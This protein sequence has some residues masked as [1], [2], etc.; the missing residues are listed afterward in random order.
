MTE[1][2]LE[3]AIATLPD[4]LAQVATT[5]AGLAS[6]SIGYFPQSVADTAVHILVEP[7]INVELPIAQQGRFI[8][9]LTSDNI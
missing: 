6:T 3:A 9:L 1:D 2:Q 4:D 8:I 5:M 7:P